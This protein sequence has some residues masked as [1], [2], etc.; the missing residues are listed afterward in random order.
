MDRTGSGIPKTTALLVAWLGCV[1]LIVTNLIQHGLWLD[2]THAWCLVRDS[3]GFADLRWNMRNEG[4]PWLW[5]LM[6]L[7]LAK[8]GAP[9]WIM[10]VL[11]GLVAVATSTLVLFRAQ[12]PIAIRVLLV[13]GYFLVFEYAALARNYAVGV[14]LLLTFADLT[15][16]GRNGL[17]FAALLVLAHVHL[18]SACLVASWAIL[19]LFQRQQRKAWQAL[20]LLLSS[21][22]ALYCVMPAEELPYGADPSRLLL[23]DTYRNVGI[24][25]TKAFIPIPDAQAGHVWNSSLAVEAGSTIATWAGPLILLAV[26]FL[27]PVDRRGRLHLAAGCLAILALPLLA[28]FLAQRYMGPL[29]AVFVACVW[30]WPA[31]KVIWPT[32]GLIT[33]LLLLQVIGGVRMSWICH[34]RPFSRSR[35]ASAYIAHRGTPVLV[36]RYDAA[37]SIS[38]YLGKPVFLVFRQEMGSFCIWNEPNSVATME[39]L[40]AALLAREPG[41][42]RV[43]SGEALDPRA[44]EAVGYEVTEMTR[45]NGSLIPRED[46]IVHT[47]EPI[48]ATKRSPS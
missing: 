6:L 7:P 11:H 46:H 1:A 19:S 24:Q 21:G 38:A 30:V 31:E 27:L 10:Q 33:G 48:G 39:Q 45:F 44:L 2:E 40:T 15:R 8:S 37:P 36:M 18:W 43:V 42:V 5:H 41:P 29:L 3:A 28:P 23:H 4:H 17:A 47:L 34:E 35:D 13:F 16:K 9:V 26:V 25:L 32:K 14:L 12:F 20:C 22:I